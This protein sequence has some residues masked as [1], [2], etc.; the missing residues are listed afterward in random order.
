MKNVGLYVAITLMCLLILY[1]FVDMRT[2]NLEGLISRNI[3]ALPKQ[4]LPSEKV[5]GEIQTLPN[6]TSQPSTIMPFPSNSGLQSFE[7]SIDSMNPESDYQ[8][9]TTPI[10]AEKTKNVGIN[11][12]LRGSVPEEY[13]GYSSMEKNP[14]Y[15]S[16]VNSAN[17]AVLKRQFDDV[18]AFKNDLAETNSRIDNMN[19]RINDISGGTKLKQ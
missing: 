13:T 17:I 12:E 11:N 15:L 1:S 18:L 7:P 9:V 19:T 6:P 14:L 10:K 4:Q 5:I 8:P 16:T 3:K 2:K